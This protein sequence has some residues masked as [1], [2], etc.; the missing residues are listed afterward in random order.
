[1]E[2]KPYNRASPGENRQTALAGDR[3]APLFPCGDFP[4]RG[5]FALLS[6]SELISN[7]KRNV[8][9]ISPS[10]GDVAAGDR[11]G[12]F[13]THRRCG[14]LVFLPPI[15]GIQNSSPEGRYHHPLNQPAKSR[16]NPLNL[17][18]P[19]HCAAPLAIPQPSA[20]WAVKPKN[21]PAHKAGPSQE[22]FTATLLHNLPPSG[23]HNLRSGG[24]STYP[25]IPLVH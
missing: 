3:N 23:G 15:G 24:P 16:R 8:A 17:L 21:L 9:R 7:S 2:R 13:P 20:L 18:N 1:M 11:R 6:A 22:P 5:K 4:R 19:G 12:A 10:G 25:T 14:C